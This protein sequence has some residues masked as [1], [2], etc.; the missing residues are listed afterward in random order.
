MK[1]VRYGGPRRAAKRKTKQRTPK[2]LIHLLHCDQVSDREE[3]SLGILPSEFSYSVD[4]CAHI[5]R[6]LSLVMF[7]FNRIV[8]LLPPS[9][10][11]IPW[12]PLAAAL[13]FSTFISTMGL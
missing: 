5:T 13:W 10:Q 3:L 12:P 6:V 11:W 2:C 4:V 1:Q 9:R 8:R 7:P